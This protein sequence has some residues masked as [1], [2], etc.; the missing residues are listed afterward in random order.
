MKKRKIAN[1]MKV[2]YD[3]NNTVQKDMSKMTKKEN[4]NIWKAM[5]IFEIMK[6]NNFMRNSLSQSTTWKFDINHNSIAVVILDQ[7][8]SDN[9]I[10]KGEFYRI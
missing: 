8:G 4:Q 5:R 6:K 2:C 1:Y 7:S 3:T 10:Y 9:S